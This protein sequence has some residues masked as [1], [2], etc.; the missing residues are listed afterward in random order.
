MDERV[1]VIDI[2]TEKTMQKSQARTT[3]KRKKTKGND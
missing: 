1:H 2:A 3:G